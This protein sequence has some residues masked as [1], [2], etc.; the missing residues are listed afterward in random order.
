MLRVSDCRFVLEWVLPFADGP[1]TAALNHCSAEDVAFEAAA[2][3]WR[4]ELRDHLDGQEATAT[5]RFVVNAAGVWTDALNERLGVRSPY[6]HELSKGV[7]VCFRRP[8]GLRH[9][10]I[11]DTE[12]NDDVSTFVPWGPV[13]LCGPT[14]TRV[15]EIGDHFGAAPEDVR[16]LLDLANRNLHARY[17][18][19]DV[20]SLRSGIRPLAVQRHFCA[21]T[22][23]A[24]LS[25]KHRLHFDPARRALAVYGGKLTSCG[26][27]AEQVRAR[28][29]PHLR[30]GA[31]P[32]IPPPETPPTVHFP[33]LDEPVPAPAW[34]RAREECHTLEDYLRR[35]TNIAQWTAR[36]GLGS[37]SENLP[38][39]REM[40]RHFAP[41]DGATD[42]SLASY[43]RHVEAWHDDVLAAV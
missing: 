2:R 21:T 39:L 42:Q 30:A 17:G 23:P 22:H 8:E 13:A 28:L 40:A 37:R 43:Q 19:E 35:R 14:E 11:F 6:R 5:A 15:T 29:S 16:S 26:L 3:R 36:G 27:L 38:A 9:G 25:R 7:Y 41:N 10:L 1:L 4:L 24:A 31:P 32:T 12:E 34:C 20:V 18:P 33:G